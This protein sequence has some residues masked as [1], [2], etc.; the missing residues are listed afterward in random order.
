MNAGQRLLET[1]V[2]VLAAHRLDH[3]IHLPAKLNVGDTLLVE[4]SWDSLE[5][6]S[7]N[8]DVLLVDAPSEVRRQTV[9]LGRG[10]GR[11][12]AIAVT[13]VALMATALLTPAV[14]G[15]LAAI[16]VILTGVIAP[17]D[18]YRRVQWGTVF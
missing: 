4:G 13:M 15:I 3:E 9:K 6:T 12:I 14:A 10:S 8:P 1:D 17:E 18:A 7:A 2:V 16:M 5:A 11:A